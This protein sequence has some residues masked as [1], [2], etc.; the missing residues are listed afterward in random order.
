[1]RPGKSSGSGETFQTTPPA[2]RLRA[3]AAGGRHGRVDVDRIAVADILAWADAWHERTGLWPGINSGRIPRIRQMT[4]AM[5][6]DALRRGRCGLSGRSSL[7]RLLA[8]RRGKQGVDVLVPLD[9]REI[10]AWANAALERTGRWPNSGSGPIAEAPGE[11]WRGVDNALRKGRRSL[12]GGAGLAEFL[13]KRRGRYHLRLSERL[14]LC[15][16]DQY[17]QRMGEWPHRSPRIIPGTGGLS[18]ESVD[19]SLRRGRCGL[20]GDSSLAR[21]LA[22]RRGVRNMK[23]LP[24]LSVPQI[25]AWADAFHQRTGRWPTHLSGSIDEAPGETWSAVHSALSRGQRGLPGGSSLR[26]LLATGRGIYNP[27]APP[28]LS[29]ERVLGWADSW[30]KRWGKWPAYDSGLIPGQNGLTWC[31]VDKALSQGRSGFEG[32]SSLARLLAERRGVRNKK[33]LP[34]LNEERILAW[35]DAARARTDRWPSRDSGRIEE[36]PGENWLGVNAALRTGGR[37]LPGGSSLAELLA[38]RRG[39]YNS[40]NPPRISIDE[41]LAWA[42]AHHERTGRWP[43]HKSGAIDGAPGET[44]STV[45]SALSRGG[46]G[47]PGGSSLARLLAK[48]RGVRVSSE[49]RPRHGA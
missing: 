36:A 20:P 48:R 24:A 11:T 16:A 49:S 14:I 34:P 27:K 9:E 26:G 39:R 8:K 32:G 17:H 6:N 21:L 12:P 41:I 22:E 25:L 33:D 45:Y 47:L 44:W 18:W 2:A 19:G 35:A 1:M 23:N 7:A 31:G 42:D 13:G 3:S 4:W 43:N 40:R 15:W 38:R 37:G 10:L 30:R 46:R 29:A 5:V 28:Q